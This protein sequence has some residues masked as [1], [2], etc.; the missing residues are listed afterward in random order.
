MQNF[1]AIDFETANGQRSSVCSVG[2]SCSQRPHRQHVLQPH[3]AR[4][5]LLCLV[6][7]GGSR[8]HAR[9]HGQCSGLFGRM[10]SNR[11]ANRRIA[12]GGAQQSV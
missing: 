10:A 5:Q 3:Q 8:S 1:A 7:S 11:A 6:L 4:T 12:F 2:G 9:G